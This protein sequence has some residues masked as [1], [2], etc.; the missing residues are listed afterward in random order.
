MLEL[1]KKD[2][3]LREFMHAFPTPKNVDDVW[4]PVRGRY[5]IVDAWAHLYQMLRFAFDDVNLAEG[6][7]WFKPFVAAMCAWQ[8]C[9]Y[10]E[11]LG[12]PPA[13]EGPKTE[14]WKKAMKM[15]AFMEFVLEGSR[16]PDLEWQERGDEIVKEQFRET[17]S[18]L[19]AERARTHR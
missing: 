9:E 16:F 19:M 4:N 12:M 6:K 7:D 10:R 18:R 13:L 2:K 3:G 14:S 15:A 8:E 11:L 5:R 17:M 1:A